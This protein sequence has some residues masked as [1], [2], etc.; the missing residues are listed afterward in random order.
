MD[1][2]AGPE[3]QTVAAFGSNLLIS[4]L[5]RIS[6]MNHLCNRYGM[7]TISCGSTIAFAT[8]LC[9]LNKLDVGL[10]WGDP[11]G[12][13]ALI[14]E[15][16]RRVGFGNDIAEG[17]KRMS[18][19]YNAP[20]LAIHVKGLEVPNH[21]PRAFSG[22]ATVY[23]MA[24]RGACHLEGDMYSVD[25]GVEIR[26]LGI[27]SG[28]RLDN[29]GKGS[30]A[31]MAQDFRAFFDTLIMCHFATVPTQNILHLLNLAVGGSYGLEDI[32]LIGA[33]AVTMKR[34]INL[35]L[36]LR[37]DDDKLPDLLLRPLPDEATYDFVPDVDKQ[38][39]EYYEHRD[40]DRETGHPSSNALSE[41][42]IDL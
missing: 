31:A 15:T 23:A 40:W 16:A 10:K 37:A 32:L 36:G 17:S 30:T 13:I 12:V 4:D 8:Y 2:V 6:L 39:T 11:E 35:K 1:D 21:D 34:L 33:R 9:E 29:E 14:H 7:D 20:E 41:L 22:M 24:S 26:E 3:F 42:D 19:K 25:M 38:V 5:R 27:N 28:Y 18:L